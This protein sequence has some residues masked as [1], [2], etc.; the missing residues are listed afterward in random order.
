[1]RKDHDV[2]PTFVSDQS[3]PT[4]PLAEVAKAVQVDPLAKSVPM[5]FQAPSP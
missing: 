4:V 5:D 1:M 2:N 3:Q